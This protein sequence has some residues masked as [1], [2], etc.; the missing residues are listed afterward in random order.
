[1]LTSKL[2]FHNNLNMKILV[3]KITNMQNMYEI[4]LTLAILEIIVIYMYSLIHY[5]FQMY[6]KNLE[7]HVLKN[8]S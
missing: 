2:K 7:K 3:V 5:Y 4:Y 6:L 8:L 1:M